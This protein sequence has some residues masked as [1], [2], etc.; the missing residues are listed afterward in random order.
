MGVCGG[1]SFLDLVL[2]GGELGEADG[3]DFVVGFDLEF[4]RLVG[5]DVSV[6]FPGASAVFHG[7]VGEVTEGAEEGAG[8]GGAEGS[9]GYRQGGWDHGCL[10]IFIFCLQFGLFLFVGYNAMRCEAMR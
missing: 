5:S 7:D 4:A 8:G 9:C 6:G 3:G 1:L 2:G 10:L